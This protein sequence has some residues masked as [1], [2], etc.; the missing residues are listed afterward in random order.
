MSKRQEIFILEILNSDKFDKDAF[1]ELR[2]LN[3]HSDAKDNVK[4]MCDILQKQYLEVDVENILANYNINE[5]I[6]FLNRLIYS[7]L[8]YKNERKNQGPLITS[9]ELEEFKNFAGQVEKIQ[10]SELAK[11]APELTTRTYLDMCRVVYDAI[12]E[13]KYPADISTAYLFCE[14]RMFS[15]KHELDEGILGIDWDSAEQF[16][17]RFNSS[18]HNEELKFGGAKLYINVESASDTFPE[19]YRQ[20][21]GNL[22]YSPYDQED[23]YQAVKM[24]NALRRNKY[25]IYFSNYREA[26]SVAKQALY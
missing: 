11:T 5:I 12:F 19:T 25:P 2:G 10:K 18:Y 15:F 17:F 3:F 9:K 16:A 1:M 13:W 20:W 14:A 8:A 6:D 7:K 4:Y 23:M 22:C 21:T 26:Y 24:Y